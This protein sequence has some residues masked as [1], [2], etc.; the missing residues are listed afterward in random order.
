MQENGK[1]LTMKSLQKLSYL[2]RCIK[3]SLR[4]YPSVYFTSRKT[5]EDVKLRKYL[6]N[7]LLYAF[8]NIIEDLSSNLNI[9][10]TQYYSIF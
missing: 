2:E 6:I 7:F 10:K 3:E 9:Y 4:L 5:G 1:K 8:L